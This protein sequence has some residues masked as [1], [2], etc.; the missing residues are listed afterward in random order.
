[1]RVWRRES[2]KCVECKIPSSIYASTNIDYQ[3]DWIC[4]DCLKILDPDTTA[5]IKKEDD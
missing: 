5:E 4:E 1:M 3:Y 2:F